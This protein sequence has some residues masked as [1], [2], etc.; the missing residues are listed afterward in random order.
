LQ[1]HEKKVNSCDWNSSPSN[2]KNHCINGVFRYAELI[3]N[4]TKST[5]NKEIPSVKIL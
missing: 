2:Q 4:L 5:Y 1:V 3:L